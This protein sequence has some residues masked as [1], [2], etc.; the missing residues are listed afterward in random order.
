MFYNIVLVSAIHQHDSAIHRYT[1]VPSFLNL[2]PTTS[3]L[4]RLSQNAGFELLASY[5][6]FPLAVCFTYGNVYVSVLLSPFPTMSTSPFCTATSP[7]LPCR[8][9]HQYHLSR[10]HIYA[11]IYICFSLPHVLHSV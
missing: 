9:V 10:V 5:N 2:P 4:S 3:H 1:C 8:L 11:L 6:K 7:L